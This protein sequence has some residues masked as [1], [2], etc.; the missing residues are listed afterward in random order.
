MAVVRMSRKNQIVVPRE[1]R[2]H[3]KLGPGDELVVVPLGSVVILAKKSK[4]PAKALAGTAR[5]LWGDP[6]AFLREERASWEREP[7][8]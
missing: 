6:E 4:R 5:G 1:A 3:L 7:R 2:E 8:R